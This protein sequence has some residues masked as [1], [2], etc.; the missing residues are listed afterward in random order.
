[1]SEKCF[2]KAR[3]Q[4]TGTKKQAT[5]QFVIAIAHQIRLHAEFFLWPHAIA[6]YQVIQVMPFKA[7][8][9]FQSLLIQQPR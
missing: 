2:P 1:M 9:Q 8:N 7:W 5:L 3:Q 4:K 6:K